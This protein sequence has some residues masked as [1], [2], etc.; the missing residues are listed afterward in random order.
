MGRGR[1]PETPLLRL[2]Q[3]SKTLALGGKGVRYI[4][5]PTEPRALLDDENLQN[6]FHTLS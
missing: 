2:D 4:E 1:S 3:F 5:F 6:L